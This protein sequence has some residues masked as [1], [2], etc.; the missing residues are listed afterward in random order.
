MPENIATT[1]PDLPPQVTR[2]LH[3]FVEVAHSAFGTALRSVVLYGSGAEG[4]LRATSDVNL[5]LVLSA[6]DRSQADQVREALRMAEAAI[7][8]SAMFLLETEIEA[9]VEAFAEKFADVLR[10]RHVLYGDD[11]FISLAVARQTAIARL[12]QVLLNQILRL[13]A[14]Y[15]LRSRRE[16]QLALVV[17][18][19]TG[20]LRSSA[21]SLLELEGHAAASP[22]EA[23]RLVASALP[24]PDWETVL[25]RLSEARETRRL[26]PGVAGDTLFRL[27]ELAMRMRSR[28]DGL[29]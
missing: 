23:L 26:P 15:V 8:L 6:F 18:D 27:I 13:R 10:R 21:A 19:A 4:R 17:A 2:G 7:R 29:S 1:A 25:A 16:E 14:L 5:I 12:K 20:P 24:E 28:V 9:A 22:K 3:D 11:P